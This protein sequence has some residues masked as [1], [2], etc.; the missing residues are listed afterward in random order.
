[1]GAQSS[2]IVSV[3]GNLSQKRESTKHYL[4][5]DTIL[6]ILKPSTYE[7]EMKYS[8]IGVRSLKTHWN[9]LVVYAILEVNGKKLTEQPERYLLWTCREKQPHVKVIALYKE[10]KSYNIA[11]KISSLSNENVD[12]CTI[13]SISLIVG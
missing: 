3:Y 13:S 9:S 8:T 6:D 1:M 10:N 7:K 12:I 2:S 11:R 5:S 4:S